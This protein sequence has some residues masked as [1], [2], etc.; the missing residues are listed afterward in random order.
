MPVPA[1]LPKHSSFLI[2][3]EQLVL[4]LHLS[5][6]GALCD[7]TVGPTGSAAPEPGFSFFQQ[8]L[9]LLNILALWGPLGNQ[10]GVTGRAKHKAQMRP[11][12]FRRLVHGFWCF[13]GVAPLSLF[14]PAIGG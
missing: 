13:C 14:L 8:E 3:V 12:S 5:L 4:E 6:E 2:L 10:E 11:A 9:L 1:P 7:R